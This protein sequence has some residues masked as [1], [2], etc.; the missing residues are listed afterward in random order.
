MI[1]DILQKGGRGV[2]GRFLIDVRPESEPVN[3]GPNK[4]QTLFLAPK[5][6]QGGSAKR[7]FL[8]ELRGIP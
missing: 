6:Q 5:W 1:P 2:P 3:A 8:R 4:P 7:A